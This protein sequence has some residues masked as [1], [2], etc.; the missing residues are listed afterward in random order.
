MAA[1]NIN[2]LA[3]LRKLLTRHR[4]QVRFDVDYNKP[5]INAVFQALEDWMEGERPAIN[6]AVND[7]RPGLSPTQKKNIVGVFLVEKAKRELL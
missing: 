4:K 6:Q 5:E 7:A 3:N 1:L 2:Q